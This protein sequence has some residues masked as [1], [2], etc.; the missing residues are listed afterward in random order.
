MAEKRIRLVV[1]TGAG[2]GIGRATAERFA[3]R[4]AEVIVADIDEPAAERTVAGIEG[5]GGR[6]YA[7]A[8]DVAEPLPGR[9]S[10]MASAPTTG[11]LTCWSTTPGS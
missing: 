10:Q 4:G 3:A 6:A 2:S 1:V 5:D 11:S 9:R 8:L 7:Y